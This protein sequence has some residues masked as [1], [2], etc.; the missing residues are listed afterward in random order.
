MVLLDG[1]ECEA[2]APENDG[3]R[4]GVKM[5]TPGPSPLLFTADDHGIPR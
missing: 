2:M 5:A 1:L 3:P 4:M